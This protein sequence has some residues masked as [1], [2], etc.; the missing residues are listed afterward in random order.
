MLNYKELD[1]VEISIEEL[2]NLLKWRDK[3][4]DIVNNYKQV[5]LEGIVDVKDGMAIYFKFID[6]H[7]TIYESY[8]EKTLVCKLK[9]E[10]LEGQYRVLESWFNE[11]M[12][13]AFKVVDATFSEMD[14]ITDT[15]TTVSTIMAYLEHFRSEVII[16][17]SPI[18]M[19][20][21]QRRKA[22]WHNRNNSK[23]N[24]IK[25]HKLVYRIPDGVR[26][27]NPD[28]IKYQ[29][30]MDSWGVRGHM[31]KLSNGKEIWVKPYTKGKGAKHS[32]IYILE[33]S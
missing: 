16:N 15:C 13:N 21:T 9:T 12:V 11:E 29:R 32:K 26:Y 22:E 19:T 20:K 25:L 7:I 33:K 18:H 14:L 2:F 30:H 28:K 8:T 1:R 3:H 23:S 24:I 5:I 31:R 10:R 27:S 6:N 17:E 4:K